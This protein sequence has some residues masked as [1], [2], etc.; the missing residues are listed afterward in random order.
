MSSIL[1]GVA[2]VVTA[3]VFVGEFVEE[4]VNKRVDK[5]ML[6]YQ[7]LFSAINAGRNDDYWGTA[8]EL[9]QTL[10]SCEPESQDEIEKLRKAYVACFGET[11]LDTLIEFY[12]WAIANSAEIDM[13]SFHNDMSRILKIAGPEVMAHGWRLFHVG[14]YFL[15]SGSTEEAMR[16]F[17]ASVLKSREIG[18]YRDSA[19]GHWGRA[20][21]LLLQ[22][23][24]NSALNEF[25]AA[26]RCSPRDFIVFIERGEEFAISEEPTL[27]GTVRSHPLLRE[28]IKWIISSMRS[29]HESGLTTMGYC[30]DFEP[31][32]FSDSP[33]VNKFF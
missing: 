16:Y 13:N 28:K 24:D 10:D 14:L 11:N 1:G 30:E 9:K 31:T 5:L 26:I 4:R 25:R 19:W 23:R 20:L 22:N 33:L 27:S 2:I 6:P 17:D 32:Y 29:E 7:H 15:R 18:D 3:G 12:L 8:I 21:T